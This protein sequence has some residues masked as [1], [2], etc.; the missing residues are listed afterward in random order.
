VVVVDVV[1]GLS[2]S[3]DKSLTLATPK[4]VVLVVDLSPPLSVA[5]QTCRSAMYWSTLSAAEAKACSGMIYFPR[6]GAEAI[7][8]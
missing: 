8:S 4:V 5:S 1:V 6:A 7:M 3:T 2:I